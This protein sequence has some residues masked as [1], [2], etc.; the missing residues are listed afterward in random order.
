M[1]AQVASK[2]ISPI[3]TIV[4]ARLLTPEAFGVVALSTMVTS[5]SSMFSD[6]GFQRYLVQRA[7]RDKEEEGQYASVAFWTN[8][9]VSCAIVLLIALFQD[10]LAEFIGCP[11][12]GLMLVVS[13]LSLP[14]TALVSVQT[15]LYQKCLDFKT[16]FGSRFGSSLLIF[17]VAVPMAYFGCGYW[18]LV[19]STLASNAF[20]AIWLTAL[21]TWKPSLFYSFAMLGKMLSFGV[22][23]LLE[24][25]ATWLNTWLGTFIISQLL[26]ETYIGYYNTSVN[27]AT[28]ITSVI[29]S[30]ILPVA[31]STF[32][33][34]KLDKSRFEHVFF[35]MQKYLAMCM[36]PV[37]V[38][39]LVFREL[40][41]TLL[42]GD[43]WLDASLFF[44][45]WMFVGCTVVVFGNLCSEAYRAFGM[46]R[47]CVLVQVVYLVPFVPTLYL[48][49]SQG[50]GVFSLLV[51]AGRLS[52][53]L[54]HLV[55]AWVALGIS[56]ARMIA[57][58]K[59]TYLQTIL[60]MVPGVVVTS[61]GLSLF[62]QLVAAVAAVIIYV[63][64]VLV[65]KDTREYALDLLGKFRGKAQRH[66]GAAE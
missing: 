17:L 35:V 38:G 52:L 23:I 11:G 25:F 13:S 53:C 46:P 64:L 57:N 60:A 44:G 65:V 21:S 40:V 8:M 22:W 66:R 31:F 37:A 28:S 26:T 47:Y 9:G 55:V 59:W 16:L 24:S 62:A 20:L 36:I 10:S 33:K 45:C 29:T 39:C 4:L 48:G 19:V 27:M 41:T 61:L 42:L 30:A 34:L 32:A 18:S 2:L 43:Q 50:W 6:A 14:L 3:T 49:A 54:I 63:V 7:F 12:L 15:A 1:L 51:P 5:L 58:Q 56:P